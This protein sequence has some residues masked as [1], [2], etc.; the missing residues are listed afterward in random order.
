L[1]RRVARANDVRAGGRGGDLAAEWVGMLRIE[2][3]K[4]LKGRGVHLHYEVSDLHEELATLEKIG[5]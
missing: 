5:L 2:F 4:E 1:S 3:Q